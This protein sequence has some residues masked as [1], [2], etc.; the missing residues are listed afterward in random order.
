[1][2]SGEYTLKVVNNSSD[3]TADYGFAFELLPPIP[4]DFD[5]DYIVDD[6]DLADFVEDWLSTDSQL[7]ENL[8]PDSIINFRDFAI[9]AENWL[10]TNPGY[11]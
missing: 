1:M 2:V 10:I 7:P 8:W 5:L 9:F 6:N 11:Y 3:E 4:G